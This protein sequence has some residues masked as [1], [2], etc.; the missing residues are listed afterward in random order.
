MTNSKNASGQYLAPT[1]KDQDF[2]IKTDRLYLSLFQ[3]HYTMAIPMICIVNILEP[4]FE[5]NSYFKVRYLV[6]NNSTSTWITS[7]THHLF[8]TCKN[9]T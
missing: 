2:K 4:Q 7:F 8:N 1:L 9:R 6:L 5:R 3:T